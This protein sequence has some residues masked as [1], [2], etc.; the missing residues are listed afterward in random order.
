MNQKIEL[1]GCHE[2]K[3]WDGYVLVKTHTVRS[4]AEE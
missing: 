1:C 3:D 4:V 2:D